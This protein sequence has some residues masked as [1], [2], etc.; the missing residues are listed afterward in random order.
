MPL[1]VPLPPPVEDA[2]RRSAWQDL[3]DP[4]KQARFLIEDGLRLRG[5]LEPDP[6]RELAAT[7]GDTHS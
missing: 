4:R 7:A 2:L 3:R 6:A 5:L 1:Y